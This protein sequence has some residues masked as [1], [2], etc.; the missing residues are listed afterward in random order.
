MKDWHYKVFPKHSADL[1]SL[2]PP[3]THHLV[4]QLLKALLA[5]IIIFFYPNSQ[6]LSF[7]K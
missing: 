1:D 3:Q 6:D 5:S 2:A 7:E 4:L